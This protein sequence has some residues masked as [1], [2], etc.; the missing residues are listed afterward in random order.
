MACAAGLTHRSLGCRPR[1]LRNVLLSA[2]ALLKAAH[3]YLSPCSAFVSTPLC[4][5]LSER[6]KK[7]ADEQRR[8]NAPPRR[9]ALATAA[10]RDGSRSLTDESV[11]M[12]LDIGA[13]MGAHQFSPMGRLHAACGP[14]MAVNEKEAEILLVQHFRYINAG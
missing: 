8:G 11:S 3:K 6:C 7:S 14:F 1:R 2:C 13:Q 10:C 12:V 5:A 4:I 9:R